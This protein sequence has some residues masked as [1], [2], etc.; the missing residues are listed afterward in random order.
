MSRQNFD[1]WVR[2]LR[3]LCPLAYPVRVFYR[4][5]PNKDDLGFCIWDR[6]SNDMPTRGRIY[7][8]PKQGSQSLF[9]TLVHEWAHAHRA[10]I[11]H[12]GQSDDEGA[13]HAVIERLIRN[14]C[15]KDD[16]PDE[17]SPKEPGTKR[18]RAR[19]AV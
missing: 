17:Q 6:A 10:Q 5:P 9:D 13:L 12:I 3:K 14:T 4:A 2:D 15:I 7:I 18:V 1:R 16:Q 11:P 19:L 8:N